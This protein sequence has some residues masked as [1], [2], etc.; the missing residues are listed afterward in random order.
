MKLFQI[1]WRK[2]L[3][4]ARVYSTSTHQL[5]HLPKTMPSLPIT[6]SAKSL[7]KR[8]TLK[9]SSKEWISPPPQIGLNLSWE[10][11]ISLS[12]SW[13]VDKYLI[14]KKC[15]NIFDAFTGDGRDDSEREL[16]RSQDYFDLEVVSTVDRCQTKCLQS[17]VVSK[18]E[19]ADRALNTLQ[20]SSTGRL[21]LPA[22]RARPRSP[23]HPRPDP[24]PGGQGGTHH[25]HHYHHYC[26]HSS[27]RLQVT[28]LQV[29]LRW[30]VRTRHSLS[31]PP[32]YNTVTKPPR[33]R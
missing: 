9:N 28:S 25:H 15:T 20:S 29:F 11:G 5:N 27:P 1:E 30:L 6:T 16:D 3:G 18:F 26:E 10:L 32:S 23:H 4:N 22:H 14:L 31:R 13:Q 19:I 2:C 8:T 21:P 12:F 33:Y 17:L 24:H 7:M